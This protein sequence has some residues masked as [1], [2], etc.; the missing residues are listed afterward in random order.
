MTPAEGLP[1]AQR[2]WV[3]VCVLLGIVLSGLDSA[4]ANI[5]LPTIAR[6][7]AASEAEVVWVVNSYQLAVAVMLLP[8]ATLGEILGLKRV[9]AIGLVLFTVA[10]LGCAA[11]P[12]LGALVGAR[13]LQGVGGACMSAIAPALVRQ[14][15]PR[16]MLGRGFAAVALGVA[17]SAATG[18]SVASLVLALGSWPW[19][20]LVNVPL[21]VAALPL[22][23]RVTPAGVRQPRPFDLLGAVLSAVS[24]GLLVVGVDTLGVDR[25]R[26]VTEVA[27]GLAGFVALVLQ[28]R[29]SRVPLLPLD[30]LA[31]PL[32]SLSIAT[33]MCSY[34][35]QILA[36]LS[37][38]FLFQ[39]V[40]GRSQVATGLLITPWP[41]LVAFAAPVAGRLVG[42]Y[43]AAILGS[44]GLAVLAAGLLLLVTLPDGAADWNIAW[45]MGLCGIGFG[46][47][48][49]PNNTT[50]MTA[51]PANRSGAAGG[52][53]GVARTMGWSFGSAIVAVLFAWRGPA[54]APDCLLAGAGL[55]AL[56]AVVS[57][58]RAAAVR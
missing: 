14:A 40:M 44:A 22:F 43:P 49:T 52:M 3:M 28:Q 57:A 1:L 25:G 38:P 50:M 56:G 37:L 41:L 58:T 35:A 55:A 2:R 4:I 5:A 32:F 20:F 15:Y 27:A 19:L 46:F 7:L 29:S 48:Q 23:L 54:A 18:P 47:F 6:D 53:T 11:S 51:G 31:I 9:Y 34:A 13:V 12:T 26:A 36:Y 8:A 30:L 45:R 16:A 17:I 33:S 10:S 39:T 42:R 21:G 24:L